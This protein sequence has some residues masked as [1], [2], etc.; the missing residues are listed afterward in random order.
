ME[1]V[2][3]AKLVVEVKAK[4]GVVVAVMEVEKVLEAPQKTRP[5]ATQ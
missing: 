3:V 1:V 2:A 5:L 4:T